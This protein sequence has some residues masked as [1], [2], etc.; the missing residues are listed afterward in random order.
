[1]FELFPFESPSQGPQVS[2]ATILRSGRNGFSTVHLFSDDPVPNQL[3]RVGERDIQPFAEGVDWANILRLIE[4]GVEHQ[5]RSA[6]PNWMGNHPPASLAK[7][8]GEHLN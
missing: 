4:I 7:P 1:M 2:R 5:D 3:K 6:G 8:S